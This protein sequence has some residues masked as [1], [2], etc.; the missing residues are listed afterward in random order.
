[1]ILATTSAL[2]LGAIA[3][4]QSPAPVSREA[5]AAFEASLS[6]TTDLPPLEE[7]PEP[8]GRY[9]PIVIEVV[10]PDTRTLPV[11]V[12]LP[13]DYDPQARWPLMLAMHGG[14]TD[15]PRSSFRGA[16]RMLEVWHEAAADA[17]W[18]IASPAMTHVIARA[19]RTEQSLP[20]EILRADQ[21]ES[22]VAALSARYAID[23][24]RV[25]STGISLGSNF[26]IAYAAARPDRFAAIV[27][28]STEGESRERLLRN[29]LH[30]PT[31]VL[32]GALDPNIRA[33]QGPRTMAA[34]CRRF[35][36]DIVYRELE[37]RA[38][39][40]FQEHYPA[41][42]EWLST[43]PRNAYPPEVL[44][45]PHQG[46][47]P[48]AKRVHWIESDT[49][50]GLVRAQVRDRSRIEI[51]TRWTRS[52]RVFLSDH[53]VSL[54]APIEIAVNGERVFH[55]SVPRSIELAKS[56][57]RDAGDSGRVYAN[58]VRIDVPVS[59]AAY[60]SSRR[61][62]ESLAPREPAGTLSFWETYATRSL[63]ARLPSLGI[64]GAVAKPAPGTDLTALHIDAVAEGSPFAQ[65]G[66]R[67]G[68]VLL[69]VDGEP[70]FGD[71]SVEELRAWLVRELDHIPREIPMRV[72]RGGTEL[73][74]RANLAL[75]PF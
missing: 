18:I 55:D 20:Y 59:S 38:H 24:D 3:A 64:E 62:S 45:V 68:D 32:E 67:E 30:V 23:D 29:L 9:Q 15:S 71:S 7:S 34:I 22:I 48:L 36:Y 44:R 54:D 47:V 58:A 2:I 11:L 63:E 53:L 60:E 57:V 16:V 26:S 4:A 27:P 19:P 74:L 14:P 6:E 39:E 46:I 73:T 8:D 65:A 17:G 43:R 49:R 75:A 37:D 25:V 28:V 41:V 50:R 72:R 52:L 51:E 56:M 31:F 10:M 40:G 69:E 5:F 42:L 12:M 35:G 33:I 13:P 70:F 21:M 1:M 61:F 66:L